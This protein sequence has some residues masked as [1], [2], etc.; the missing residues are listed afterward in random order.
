M[1]DAPRLGPYSPCPRELF[2]KPDQFQDSV[3]IARS[4]L[5][6]DGPSR[7]LIA[8]LVKNTGAL[9]ADSI[10]KWSLTMSYEAVDHVPQWYVVH[11][12]PKQEDRAYSNL[13]SWGVSLC[14][15]D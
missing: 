12:N 10:S 3:S 11:T 6:G 7:Y 5:A 1:H 2:S 9:A 8:S 15:F 4:D 13:R 14:F